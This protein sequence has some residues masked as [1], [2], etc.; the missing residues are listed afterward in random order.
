[1]VLVCN[2]IAGNW[3]NLRDLC[4]E[5]K[6]GIWLLPLDVCD[7]PLED[8]DL[9]AIGADSLSATLPLFLSVRCWRERNIYGGNA[10]EATLAER[11]GG[12]ARRTKVGH[13]A[14]KPLQQVTL[15]PCS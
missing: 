5:I 4:L 6:G 8:L 14:P 15:V 13:I 10:P 7:W 12:N 3:E 11:P 9:V 1:M 2:S